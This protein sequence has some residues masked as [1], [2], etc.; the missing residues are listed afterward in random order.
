[1]VG[2]VAERRE[3]RTAEIVTAAWELSRVHGIGGL[4]LHALAREVGIR[5]P[6]LYV[7]FD[8]KHA[9]FDAMFA[10]GNRQLLE[11][12]DSLDLPNDPRV[13]LKVFMH[14]F[15]TF[16]VED[17]ERQALMF[18]RTIPGFEPSAA[19][20]A[21]AEIVLGRAIALL[22]TAGT[23]DQE[24]VDCFVAMVAGII[25]AQVANDPDGDRWIRHLD[26]LIDLYLDD[27]SR[28]RRKP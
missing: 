24:D 14:E 22:A 15:V 20:Y 26:R 23:D 1:M 18:A 4:S 9:L 27:A 21:I 19:S 7:Y 3:A 25:G 5:Q 2:K 28:R 13:A 8:S 11:R 10:D 16:S 6:S 12:I 17:P